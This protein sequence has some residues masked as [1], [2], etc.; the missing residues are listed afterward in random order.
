MTG[1][2]SIVFTR[3]AISNETFIPKSNNLNNSIVD[4]DAS[5]RY[6]Y[7]MCQDM[8]T[9]LYTRWDYNEEAQKFEARQNR[10]RAFENMVISYF[11]TIIPESKIESYYTT[12]TQ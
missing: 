2:T 3:K 5:Q 12:G 7:S 8:P 6:P 10:V 4:I 9:G 1:G 11:Q